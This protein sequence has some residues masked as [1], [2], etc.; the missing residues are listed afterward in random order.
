MYTTPQNYFLSQSILV[1]AA[2]S[3][4]TL[5]FSETYLVGVSTAYANSFGTVLPRVFHIDLVN[6][7][8]TVLANLFTQQFAGS[9]IAPPLVDWTAQSADVTAALQSLAGQTVQLQITATIPQN[10]TGGAGFGLDNVSL[11][12]TTTPEPGT[13]GLILVGFGALAL[14][15]R[16]TLWGGGANFVRRGKLQQEPRRARRWNRDETPDRALAWL[17][18]RPVSA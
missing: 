6:G 14:R 18:K 3:A 7:S 10:F 15:R 13:L 11:I 16:V 12:A 4:A 5:S 8:G 17:Q 1:P 2:V 9:N